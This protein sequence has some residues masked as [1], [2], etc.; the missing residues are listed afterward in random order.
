MKEQK[1]SA[2]IRSMEFDALWTA[3]QAVL[4][5]RKFNVSARI[6]FDEACR[7]TGATSGYVAL[8]SETGEENEVLFLEAGG[9]PCTVD[10]DLP[11]PIR[12]LRAQSYHTG[13]AVFENDFMK[14]EWMKF[15]PKGHVELSNVMFAPLNI[16]GKTVGIMGLANKKEAFTSNDAA[17]AAAF[18]EIG[19]IAL[20]NSR[21]LDQLDE[22]VKELEE[23]NTVLVEREMRIIEMKKEV[24]TLCQEMGKEIAYPEIWE[25]D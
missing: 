15:M 13:Q 4:K 21:T 9:K 23:F 7:M 12:G 25:E 11:M 19:A 1:T 17:I 14:S 5:H 3:A 2:K 22:S 16:E 6:I 8:L 24:N 20:Q 10:P 18:G